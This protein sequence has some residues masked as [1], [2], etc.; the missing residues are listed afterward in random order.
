MGIH[1]SSDDAYV[2]ELAK[3]EHRPVVVNG[4]YIEPIER[5]AGGK[6]DAPFEA[7]PKMLY[8]GELAD[9]GP[10]IAQFIVVQD[11]SGELIATGQG[12]CTTQE[13]AL[14]GVMDRQRELARQAAHRAHD[15]RWMSDK[16]KAEAAAIDESTIEHLPEIPETPIRRRG[17]PAKQA[18]QP[19]EG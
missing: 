11:E 16:A 17:R 7:Y 8:R 10:R 6:K 2:K 3:W 14:S 1:R 4:T 12:F 9:G 13:A 5:S 19:A 15:E 18:A